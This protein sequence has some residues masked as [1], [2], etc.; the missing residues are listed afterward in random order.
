[1]RK[2]II[3]ISVMMAFLMMLYANSAAA[4]DEVTIHAWTDK[5]QY[6]P[7]ET[8]TLYITV[9][10][11]LPDTDVIIKNISIVYVPWHAYVKDHWEGNQSFTDINEICQMKGG[12][13]Y[14]EVKFTV[15]TG[16]R[17]VSATAW[18]TVKLDKP[19][20]DPDTY[21]VGIN[22][23]GSPYPTTIEDMNVWMT[24]LTVAMVICTIILAIVIFLS[25]R[26]ARA[27]RMVA[28][29]PKAKAE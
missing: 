13:Y 6:K 26:E 5:V 10:N 4:Q 9:R 2:K 14:K 28:P 23:A 29:P 27:P 18:I 25:T 15:P 17:G 3:A 1:M 16:G 12:V 24:S 19:V 20:H 8:G 11:D 21:H 7:G 22:V